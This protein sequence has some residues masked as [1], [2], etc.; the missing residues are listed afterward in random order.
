MAHSIR[1][2]SKQF[3]L[4]SN[5]CLCVCSLTAPSVKVFKRYET[6]I[7]SWPFNDEM[8]IAHWLKACCWTFGKIKWYELNWM[9]VDFRNIVY[10]VKSQ[11]P[12][13]KSTQIS[14][15]CCIQWLAKKRIIRNAVAEICQ[16]YLNFYTFKIQINRNFI[17]IL[18]CEITLLSNFS[19]F[20]NKVY[21][22][23]D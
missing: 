4:K 8:R 12:F 6:D 23:S 16:I 15:D 21:I 13:F 7:T 11:F 18:L 1:F 22:G 20:V 14:L 2:G 3:T 19:F 10:I 17:R 5:R 9:C